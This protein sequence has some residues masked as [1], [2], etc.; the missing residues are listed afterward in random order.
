MIV[1]GIES[2]TAQTSVALG[3][4]Q[5][6]IASCLMS[7]GSSA[8]EFLLPSIRFLLDRAKLSFDNIAGVAVGRGPGLFT[9][10]RVGISTAKTM[11]QALSVPIVAISSLDAL[12]FDV[13]YTHRVIC[14]VLDAKRG[15]V[16]FALYRQVPG[17]ITRI[18]EYSVGTVDRLSAEI[19]GY[20][21]EVLLVGNGALLYRQQLEE[22]P[23]VEFG[24]AANGF[25]RASSLVELALPRFLREDY[26]QLFELEPMYMRRSD[27]EIKWDEKRAG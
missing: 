6:I 20:G 14:P 4:E 18:T 22:I 15:E 26:D 24:S 10:M 27:A 11:A 8:D 17:G 23:R 13:R 1:L 5:E 12:G 21:S 9:S 19:Q 3:R 25:P 7:R 16:F 2:S